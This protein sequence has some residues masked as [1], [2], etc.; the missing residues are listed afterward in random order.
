M[1]KIKLCFVNCAECGNQTTEDEGMPIHVPLV[2]VLGNVE[3][4]E[5]D[6]WLCPV[7]ASGEKP[8]TKLEDHPLYDDGL[9]DNEEAF[10]EII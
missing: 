1:S 7:C 10:V 5:H 2:D 6:G 8:V 9:F 3:D 4:Y